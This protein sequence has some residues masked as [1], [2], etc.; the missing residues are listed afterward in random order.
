MR[1][2]L[3]VRHVRLASLLGVLAGSAVGVVATAL[4]GTAVAQHVPAPPQAVLEATHLPPLLTL[5]GEPVRLAYDVHCIP[6]GIDDPE[7]S[8]DASGTAYVRAV[9]ETTFSPIPLRPEDANGQR[10]LTTVVPPA[11]ASGS[12]G[13]E[14]YAVSSRSAATGGSLT[15]P[16]GGAEAPNRS[17]PLGGRRPT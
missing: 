1:R 15:T 16:A 14:Y 2:S 6:A 13:F 17:L 9:G 10:Q 11:L 7:W 4:A 5:P 3:N 12:G 8:C